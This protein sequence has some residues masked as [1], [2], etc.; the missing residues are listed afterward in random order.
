MPAPFHRLDASQT[1]APEVSPLLY[2]FILC[3]GSNS[4]FP[5]EQ[6]LLKET[7]F[8]GYL[9]KLLFN[10]VNS[11]T[12]SGISFKLE[13]HIRSVSKLRLYKVAKIEVQ[14]DRL[15]SARPLAPSSLWV[16]ELQSPGC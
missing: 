16:A 1:A 3:I 14:P 15:S 10:G 11:A 13:I 6:C 2:G 4:V 5:V 9:G 7:F 12:L 8:K